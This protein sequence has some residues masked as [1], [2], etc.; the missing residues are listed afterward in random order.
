MPVQD[1]FKRVRKSWVWRKSKRSPH[2]DVDGKVL[3]GVLESVFWSTGVSAPR[4]EEVNSTIEE[5]R[6][7]KRKGRPSRF[8]LAG[9]LP[10]YARPYD[11]SIEPGASPSSS[12]VGTQ[13]RMLRAASIRGGSSSP[14]SLV[15][16]REK[17]PVP[18]YPPSLPSIETLSIVLHRLRTKAL[19]I[20]FEDALLLR[21]CLY[22]EVVHWC[23]LVVWIG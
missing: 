9:P 21:Q 22:I 4:V 15:V 8:E 10:L 16:D 7:K 17:D 3:P 23:I 20:I 6:G 2:A 1:V 12:A 19:V 5:Q 14:S 11:G 18:L 13:R